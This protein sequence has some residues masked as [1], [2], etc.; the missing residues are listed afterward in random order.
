[1]AAGLWDGPVEPLPALDELRRAVEA[2]FPAKGAPQQQRSSIES[3]RALIEPLALK[4]VGPRAIYD[5][6]RHEHA[7]FSGSVSAVKR[8]CSAVKREH[9]VQA[10]R[11]ARRG[12]AS[13]STP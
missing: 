1:V 7:E 4:G 11:S 6:L 12:G 10:G 2:Q 8:M 3:Y 5:R 9:G 13:S